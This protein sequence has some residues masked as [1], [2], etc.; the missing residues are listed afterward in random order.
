MIH[1]F[2]VNFS[3]DFQNGEPLQVTNTALHIKDTVKAMQGNLL[4]LVPE[5]RAMLNRLRRELLE[6]VR[7]FDSNL[8]SSETQT[9]TPEPPHIR[10]I[11]EP[12]ILPNTTP[13]VLRVQPRFVLLR[14]N[15]NCKNVL[16]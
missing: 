8:K 3:F 1:F 6:P 11:R 14:T 5:V 2:R 10:S 9:T 4:T 15:S 7:A 16:F 13:D 12:D